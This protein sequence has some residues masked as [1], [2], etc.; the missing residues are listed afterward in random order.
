MLDPVIEAQLIAL[1]RNVAAEEI[2]PRFRNLSAREVDRKSRFDD[3]VTEADLCSEGE[4][5]RGLQKLL[6]GACI[7]GEE[8][9]AAD[10][11]VL[12][13]LDD[14]ELAVIIDPIDGTW[15]YAHGISTYGV[16]IAV[17]EAGKTVYGL[18][19]DPVLDDWIDARRGGGTWYNRP[20]Q[21]A[22]RL[23]VGE[24]N[25]HDQLTG[26]VAP[27]NFPPEQQALVSE[28]ALTY[29]RAHTLRCCCHEYRT[30]AQGGVDFFINPK[31]HVW[32]HAAGILAVEEA[33]G[34]V[35]M[36]DG[37]E[38]KPSL[39]SGIILSAKNQALIEKLMDQFACLNAP[40]QA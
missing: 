36:L 34:S 37:S 13:Q 17:I 4:I 24:P 6:P 10:P 2:R 21:R 25:P 28:K 31:P 19:Y 33:G 12:D 5:T 16:L 27:V 23:A 3:L 32:D 30:L 8:A 29:A 38:Y 15:N 9:V 18:L 39:R 22:L 40:Y 14:A 11:K 26:F 1:V 7:I 35:R 20:G